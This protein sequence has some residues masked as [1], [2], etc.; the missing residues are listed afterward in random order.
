MYATPESLPSI[1]TKGVEGNLVVSG[2]IYVIAGGGFGV[3]WRLNTAQVFARAKISAA[4]IFSA[5]DDEGLAA[6]PSQA[7]EGETEESVRPSTPLDQDTT[8][9]PPA[10]PG[11]KRRVAAGSS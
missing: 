8:P 4:D 1:F 6:A 2:S 5:E 10:A 3:T 7:V 9:V 11:R